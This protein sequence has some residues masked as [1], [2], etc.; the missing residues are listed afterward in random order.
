MDGAP[1]PRRSRCRAASSPCTSRSAWRWRRSHTHL[2]HDPAGRRCGAAIFLVSVTLLPRSLPHPLRRRHRA[3]GLRG[4]AHLPDARPG[5]DAL[6]VLHGAS[7][8]DR[9]TGLGEHCGRA[10]SCII[11]Q[12]IC[13]ALL[14]DSG[15]QLSLLRSA[16][17]VT[18]REAVL[19]LRHRPLPGR[20]LRLLRAPARGSATLA[21]Y[22]RQL[23]LDAGQAGAEDATQAKS[24]FLASMSHEIRT[25]MNGV[26]RHDGAAARHRRSRRNSANTARRC[27][28]RRTRLLTIIDGILDLSKIEAGQARSRDRRSSTCATPLE[29]AVR[30][31]RV[32]A[33]AAR[34]SS[35]SCA[36]TGGRAAAGRRRRRRASARCCSTCSSNAV[37]FTPRGDVLVRTCAWSTPSAR[38]RRSCARRARHRHR[39]RAGRAGAPVPAIYGQA[40]ALDDAPLS[41]A[42]ASASPSRRQPRRA[43]GRVADG[44]ERAGRRLHLRGAR[45]C[46][47]RRACRGRASRQRCSGSACSSPTT[48]KPPAPHVHDQLAHAGLRR[49]PPGRAPR[50]YSALR[51]AAR[52]G[53][54]FDMALIDGRMPSLATARALGGEI[55]RDALVAGTMLVY[56]ASMPR[57]LDGQR[58]R[59][60]P[61]SPRRW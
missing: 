33:D 54:A 5:G 7:P 44:R 3:A 28:R 32:Q 55:K 15:V 36:W 22:R 34:G 27:A 14:H 20:R 49:P 11:A 39:H 40:D 8:D 45:S 29:D 43:D 19:P 21:D 4:A 38:G 25:P 50:D 26:D 18:T 30:P 23:E 51:E 41:A 42:R 37:K 2:G 53:N 52:A 31:R 59:R 58:R 10:R 9:C 13:C 12:H 6:L 48:A 56:L 35:S 60:A 16:A 61:G 1:R 57:R 17:Y 46:S 24:R 47:R